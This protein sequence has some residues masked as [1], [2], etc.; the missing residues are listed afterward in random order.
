[1]ML[2]IVGEVLAQ[3]TQAAK[4]ATQTATAGG[5]LPAAGV[6]LPLIILTSVA[7]LLI[8]FGATKF[9]QAFKKF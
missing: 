6:S 2:T 9:F 8:I 7:I 5:E 1:M 4:G 3:T